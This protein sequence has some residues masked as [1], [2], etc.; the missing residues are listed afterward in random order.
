MDTTAREPNPGEIRMIDYNIPAELGYT[1]DDEWVRS[2]EELVTIGV[3]DFAQEQLG[4][5]VFVELPPAGTAVT[6]GEA[7]G[8]STSCISISLYYD[9]LCRRNGNWSLVAPV[10]TNY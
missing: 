6:R 8:I 3:T 4:D 10:I 9:L 7:F 2:H 1:A 5:I